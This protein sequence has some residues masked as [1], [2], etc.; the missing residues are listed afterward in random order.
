MNR[1]IAHSNKT[2]PCEDQ[3]IPE[4]GLCMKHMVLFEIWI[5]EHEG[6]RVYDTDYP[7]NWKRSIFHRWLDKIGNTTANKIYQNSQ[8][9]PIHDSTNRRQPGFRSIG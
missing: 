7:K 3:F 8:K 4:A 5:D 9:S 1:C 6:H 2:V